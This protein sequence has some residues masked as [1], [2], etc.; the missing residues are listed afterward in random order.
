MPLTIATAT[1]RNARLAK[2]RGRRP[3]SKIVRGL[4][5]RPI[6]LFRSRVYRRRLIAD[7]LVADDI[8]A[9]E[10]WRHIGID[11]IVV[12][13]LAAVFDQPAPRVACLD[14]IPQILEG[15]RR[16][17]RMAQNVVVLP[18]QFIFRVAADANQIGVDVG[19]DAFEIGSGNN[20]DFFTQH[21]FALSDGEI[22]FH[23]RIPL[24]ETSMSSHC[25]TAWLIVV[26]AQDNGLPPGAQD[27]RLSSSC[28]ITGVGNKRVNDV[29]SKLTGS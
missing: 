8:F 25:K 20:G 1:A 10:N 16:H 23:G 4:G 7:R 18:D 9:V 13:V 6:S 3:K 19:D 17:V 22:D 14:G 29:A 27:Q 11:P 24:T 5:R 21:H 15:L 28:R 26:R 2:I 12:S